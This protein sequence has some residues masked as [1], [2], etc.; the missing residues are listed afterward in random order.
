MLKP[1]LKSQIDKLW[2]RFF[3]GGIANH[4]TAIE[5]ISYLIFMK[6][7]EDM[8]YQH[9][10]AAERRGEKYTSIF[11]GQ[12]NCRWS[13]WIQMPA[14]EMLAHVRDKVF[15]F[16]K[17]LKGEESLFGVAMRDAV[18]MIPRPSLLQEAV[19][20]IDELNVT[21]QNLD[22]QGD[23]YEYL[24]SS[25]QSSGL[26]GAF[27]TPR[28][29]IRMMVKLVDPKIGERICDPAAGTA[30]FLVNAFLHILEQNTYKDSIEYDEDGVP[31]HLVAEKLDKKQRNFLKEKAFYGFDFDTTMVRIGIMNLILHG[32][33]KPQFQYADTLSKAFEQR[34]KYDVILANPPFKGAIDK[35]DISDQFKVKSTK[36]ELLFMEL[37]LRLLVRGGR[38]AVIVPDGVLFGS[39]NAHVA[40]RK[41]LVEENQ[42]E[43][44]ISMP[45]G[46]FKPYAGVSTAVVIFT[47]GGETDKVWFYDMTADGFSL[48]DKRQKTKENDI[49]DIVAKWK[50]RDSKKKPGRGEKWF[51]VDVKEIRE[52]KYDLSVSKYKEVQHEEFQYDS[53]VVIAEKVLKM[54]DEIIS[55]IQAIKGLLS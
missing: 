15:P 7:L 21:Q 41:M 51:W 55:E 10:R 14:D 26:T 16:V 12:E 3:A 36:T 22:T 33:G 28:H 52:N 45:S 13:H 35:S 6:R 54:E 50:V 8:D 38:A 25:L 34:E 39:S 11:K 47:K 19:K 29:I 20:I 46:V 44:A 32:I 1:E 18:F 53:P 23:I 4:L 40:V 31:H 5:Q 43:G 30:G 9:A 27:R 24:L 2:N 49:P 42:L 17:N 48:D 37:F